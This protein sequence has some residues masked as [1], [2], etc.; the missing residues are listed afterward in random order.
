MPYS[1]AAVMTSASATDPPAAT[2]YLTPRVEATSMES[3]KG[4]K[5]SEARA[6]PSSVFRKADCEGKH[7]VYN[8]KGTRA[9]THRELIRE[10]GFG[11]LRKH[12]VRDEILYIYIDSHYTHTHTHTHI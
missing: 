10:S 4:K 5:A 3:R 2:T 8:T 11:S 6:T 1:S 12:R 9:H 7:T